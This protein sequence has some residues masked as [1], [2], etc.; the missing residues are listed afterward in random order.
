MNINELNA[1]LVSE[2]REIA[3]LIGIADVEKLRKHELVAKIVETGEEEAKQAASEAEELATENVAEALGER[4]RKRTRTV[5]SVE[6]VSVRNT[7]DDFATDNRE[8][9]AP[10]EGRQETVAASKPANGT[11]ME[12]PTGSLDFDNVIV[13]EG[14]LEI[15]PDGYG[16][17]RSSDY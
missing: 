9:A 15:M 12:G 16:F 13:N 3:K 7:R 17:L 1:K 11:K 4:P 8:P 14:V 2:L 6:P 10:A 5:K